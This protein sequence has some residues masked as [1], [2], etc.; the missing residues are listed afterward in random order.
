[1]EGNPME[2][3]PQLILTDPE[4]HILLAHTPDAFAAAL[5]GDADGLARLRATCAEVPCGLI[6][7][8]P[9]PPDGDAPLCT[10]PYIA[11]CRDVFRDPL[12]TGAD[13]FYLRGGETFRALRAAVLA[14]TDRSSAPLMAELSALIKRLVQIA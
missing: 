5:A 4:E 3:H 6:L 1:M 13:F 2:P 11:L 10:E 8:C 7:T 9:P 12:R 14:V